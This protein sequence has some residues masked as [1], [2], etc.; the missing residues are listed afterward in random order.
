[1]SRLE[2]IVR[3][4]I[5]GDVFSARVL[6]PAQPPIDQQEDIVVTWGNPISLQAKAI[7]VTNLHGGAKLQEQSRTTITRRVT[8]PDDPTQFVDV[9]A[10]QHIR[11]KDQVGAL[12]EFTFN[13]Q[14]N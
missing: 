1:M 7:G 3:P 9:Q 2:G 12:H 6:P 13:P 14:N 5:P 4:F 8:N 10:I 11:L